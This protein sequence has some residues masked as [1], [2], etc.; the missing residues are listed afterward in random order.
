[1]TELG[2]RSASQ[3]LRTY[4]PMQTADLKGGIY[5]VKE[6][7][8][9]YPIPIDPALVR[10][11]LLREIGWLEAAGADGGMAQRLRAN[12]PLDV[13]R[14]DTSRGVAVE[15]FPRVWLCAACQRVGRSETRPCRCGQRRWTQLQFVGFH[16]CG[17]VVE[18]WI[19][20][21]PTHDDTRMVA[22]RSA[23]A[24]DIRFV[25]PECHQQTQQGL[26]F[27]RQCVCG[28][29]TITWNVH[30]ARSVYAPRG[31]SWINPAQPERVNELND[32][33]GAAAALSWVL[34]GM[35]TL[36]PEP[37]EQRPT[38]DQ[39]V[40]ALVDQ[41]VDPSI[42]NLAA[43]QAEAG[44]HL[45]Q[46]SADPAAHLSAEALDEARHEATEIAMALWQG[47]TRIADLVTA[48]PSTHLTDLYENAYPNALRRAGLAAVDFVD[49]FP[50]LTAMYG[51]TRGGTDTATPPRL[52]PFAHPQAG[53]RLHGELAETEA[54]HI[55]LDPHQVAKWLITRGHALPDYD[56]AGE[57]SAARTAILAAVH[58]PE[59]G[60]QI[61]VTTVGSDLLTLI[62]TYAHRAIRITAV[63]AGIDRDALSEYLTPLHLGFFL[64]AAARGGFVLG[65]LQ[66]VYETELDNLLDDF[67][68]AEHRCPLDPGCSRGAGAC[69]ACLH[70][71]EP[72]CRWFNTLLDR[73]SLFGQAGYL[74]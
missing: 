72:S 19:N 17:A 47:R 37:L 9:A 53:Y 58:I 1:M 6:W 5:R 26:G 2:Q 67:V 39:F 41:G 70:L 61:P 33:G 22:T 13:V 60:E 52:V 21:C 23:K 74:D 35:S 64:F 42:A 48:S 65:G 25:C 32:R 66:A 34:T 11:R 20:R 18:P 71:G 38:R 51:Y 27:N 54:L 29:G 40:G 43:D 14:L 8:G 45:D 55:R 62:H 16:T 59:P 44:G 56:P 49:R 4:L 10:R 24:S 31:M 36:R 73:A 63:F 57:D 28:Q 50:V 68:E 3:I 12:A 15:R 46:P 69:T 7:S 30:K